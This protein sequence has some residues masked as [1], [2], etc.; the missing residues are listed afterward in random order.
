MNEIPRARYSGPTAHGETIVIPGPEGTYDIRLIGVSEGGYVLRVERVD[1]A[2]G[3][4][5]YQTFRGKVE[6]GTVHEYE[7]TVTETGIFATLK[8]RVNI[9]PDTLSKQSKGKYVDATLSFRKA[10]GLK[11]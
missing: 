11:I 2:S 8:A 6:T 1:M 3:Q 7:A 9:Q 4:L 10:T 5:T